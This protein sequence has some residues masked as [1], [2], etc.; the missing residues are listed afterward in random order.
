MNTIICPE[1]VKYQEYIYL[2]KGAYKPKWTRA[3]SNDIVRLFQVIRDIEGT[4][5]CLFIHRHKVPQD[6]N[7]TYYYISCNIRPNKK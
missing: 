5:T 4:D 6:S 7:I 3:I 1:A 2:M